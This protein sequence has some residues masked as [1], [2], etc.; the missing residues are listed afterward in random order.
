L[1]DGDFEAYVEH[2]AIDVPLFDEQLKYLKDAPPLPTSKYPKQFVEMDRQAQPATFRWLLLQRLSDADGRRHRERP[3]GGRDRQECGA[4]SDEWGQEQRGG[5]AA[6]GA[7]RS[8]LRRAC[9]FVLRI[10]DA[11]AACRFLGRCEELVAFGERERA[12]RKAKE[13]A[14]P[15]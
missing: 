9:H 13:T 8:R 2:F 10:Q 7:V 15:A 4:M 14:S 5:G 11:A 6:P 1:T 3:E 12:G